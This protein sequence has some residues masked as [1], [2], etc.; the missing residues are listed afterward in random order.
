MDR[1]FYYQNRAAEHQREISRE[2]ATRNLLK[3][4]KRAPLNANQAKGL[5]LR[6][7]P[8]VIVMTILLISFLR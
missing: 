2:L 3:D 8:A 5:V 4:S 1:N 7:A 6:A